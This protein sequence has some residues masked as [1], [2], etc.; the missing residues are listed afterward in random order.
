MKFRL[1]IVA[2]TAAAAAAATLVGCSSS[3]QTTGPD[4]A[5]LVQDSA[6]TMRDVNSAHVVLTAEGRVPNLKVTK[7]EADVASKPTAVGTGEATLQMGADKT[8]SAKIIFVDGHLYSD[9]A[10][11]GKFTDYGQ[12]N[13]I[14]DVSVILDT[15]KGLANALAKLKDPKAQGSE[16]IDGTKATKITGTSSTNDVAQLAGSK[17]A[18]EKEQTVPVTVWIAQDDPHHLLKAEIEPKP[19]TNVTVTLSDFGKQ[20]SATKPA[21]TNP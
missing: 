16:D 2:T 5:T 9:I 17:L 15:Q 3:G 4:A 21:V 8:Q 13:S 7:L 20:V 18:P 19:G 1:G 6:N 14:Y 12:G 10:D 11:P